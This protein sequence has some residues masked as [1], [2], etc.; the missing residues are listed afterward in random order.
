[1]HVDNVGGFESIDQ[2]AIACKDRA[3]MF[4][5]GTNAFGDDRCYRDG[6]KCICETAANDDGTCDIKEHMGY[7]LYRFTNWESGK[8]QFSYC[9]QRQILLS[10]SIF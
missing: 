9:Q 4:I 10:H 7:N 2:C 3:S 1:M 8:Y 6:C 5:F